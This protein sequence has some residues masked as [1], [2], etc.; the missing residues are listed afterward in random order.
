MT[1]GR[2]LFLVGMTLVIHVVE[3]TYRFPEF[4]I[5][6]VSPRKISHRISHRV[7][8][9][10]KTFRLNPFVQNRERLCSLRHRSEF[11]A[12]RSRLVE[13]G[14][15]TMHGQS[16]TSGPADAAESKIVIGVCAVFII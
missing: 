5:G 8:M 14:E 4:D 15:P 16:V 13:G 10:A 11:I 12:E 2:A 7:A 6:T 9:F 3:Q 1:I